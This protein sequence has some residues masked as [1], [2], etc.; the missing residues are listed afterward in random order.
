M[1]IIQ[2]EFSDQTNSQM[3]RI[4]LNQICTVKPI[5]FILYVPFY[6]VHENRYHSHL[7]HIKHT[8]MPIFVQ[9]IIWS[10]FE[11]LKMCI[12][13]NI[14]EQPTNMTYTQLMMIWIKQ[15][16]IFNHLL[17]EKNYVMISSNFYTDVYLFKI[18]IQ[19]MTVHFVFRILIIFELYWLRCNYFAEF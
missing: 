17:I 2:T 13:L 11:L 18:E 3:H 10:V 8:I 14:F 12:I 6:Y 7:I 4:S 15:N 9:V 5:R 16:R 19:Q 1:K